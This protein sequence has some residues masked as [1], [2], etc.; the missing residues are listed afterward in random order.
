[1]RWGVV[2]AVGDGVDRN[3]IGSIQAVID[4]VTSVDTVVGVFALIKGLPVAIGHF[5]DQ[6][7]NL[8]VGAGDSGQEGDLAVARVPPGAAPS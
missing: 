4:M 2:F 3:F 6:T 1:M 7:L 5:C 8:T